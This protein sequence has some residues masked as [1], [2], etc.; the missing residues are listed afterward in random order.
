MVERF[1]NSNPPLPLLLAGLLTTDQIQGR[2]LPGGSIS[3][4]TAV[5]TVF[6]IKA[7]I[8]TVAEPEADL[9]HSDIPSFN[10]ICASSKRVGVMTQGLQH[11][12][13]HDRVTMPD[14]HYYLSVLT[15]TNLY[16][17][18]QSKRD[19]S[20]WPHH[21]TNF[22]LKRG[23]RLV[24]TY[25]ERGAEFRHQQQR[26]KIN[27][28]LAKNRVDTTGAGDV[29]AT[30]FILALNKGEELA[31]RIA[32][33]SIENIGPM[34]LPDLAEIEQRM[35]AGQLDVTSCNRRAFT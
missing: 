7:R 9:S 23:A 28:F 17:C 27:A 16:T 1:A 35:I 22:A 2:R 15:C 24:T 3:Y 33:A 19:T 20:F 31:E 8:L 13:D 32:V 18:F 34:P 10:A 11:T 30:A 26:F 14:T 4:S 6:G 25:S 29:F 21:W 5:A 12:L